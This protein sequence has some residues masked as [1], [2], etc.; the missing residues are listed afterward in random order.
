MPYCDGLQPLLFRSSTI[1]QY[2]SLDLRQPFPHQ[3]HKSQEEADIGS[4]VTCR[5]REKKIGHPSRWSTKQIMAENKQGQFKL[6]AMATKG[7][8]LGSTLWYSC[9]RRSPSLRSAKLRG[10]RLAALE[11]IVGLKLADSSLCTRFLLQVSFIAWAISP[12]F[13]SIPTDVH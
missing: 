3:A 13:C 9:L 6:L 8:E 2:A 4:L 11:V 5:T 1:E 7:S 12:Q 10:L